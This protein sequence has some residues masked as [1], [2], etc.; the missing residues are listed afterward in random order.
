MVVVNFPHN[1]TGVTLSREEQAELLRQVARVG[2]YLVWDGAFGELTY[3]E[4]PLPDPTLVYERALSMGTMSKAYG[5]PGLRVG[6]MMGPP[7][8]LEHCAHLR[9]YTLLHLSPLVELLAQHAIEGA[10]V[11]V[12]RRLA[13]A[14]EHRQMVS[15][16]I[17][18]EEGIA[19]WVPPAGGVCGFPRFHDAI[20]VDRF[21]E[22][23]AEEHRVLLV[24]GS[25]FGQPRHAR[26]GFGCS[27]AE[28]TQGL[29]ATSRLL[30]EVL[31]RPAPALQAEKT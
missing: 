9:D 2:A 7:E 8:L 3:G 21:C 27:R 11:L 16:W 1:P 6:W 15:E 25:C 24:P 10:D 20:D 5:L 26:L 30:A 17:A 13:A 19:G 31:G 22:R 28:L 14:R 29:A 23:L 18:A 4:P 12:A